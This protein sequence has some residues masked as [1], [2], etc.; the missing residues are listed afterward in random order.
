MCIKHFITVEPVIHFVKMQFLSKVLL[1]LRIWESAENVIKIITFHILESFLP[2]L[3][4]ILP[5]HE[6]K[7]ESI[8]VTCNI[9]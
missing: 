2:L 4:S 5:G 8:H 3:L 7:S 9:L 1:R 6:F